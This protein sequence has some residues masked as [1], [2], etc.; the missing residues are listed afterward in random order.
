MCCAEVITFDLGHLSAVCVSAMLLQ[1]C[2][3]LCDPM[4]CGSTDS[5]VHG[6]LRQEYWTELP[7]LLQGL[8]PSEGKP[9]S[10]TSRV[11]DH[12]HH[13]AGYMPI[14]QDGRTETWKVKVTR[15]KVCSLQELRLR[16]EPGNSDF[17]DLAFNKSMLLSSGEGTTQRREHISS[18]KNS[19]K[20]AGGL[21][22]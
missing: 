14:T 6:I 1:S 13:S 11:L 18:V 20:G 3:T 12:W 5:S 4:D 9:V 21:W 19:R 22:V 16:R 15:L 2:P 10:L 8:F 7:C 17:R